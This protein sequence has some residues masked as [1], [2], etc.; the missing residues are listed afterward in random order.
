MGYLRLQ[1]IIHLV[2]NEILI[3]HEK[4]ELDESGTGNVPNPWR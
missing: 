1:R 4:D 2:K 3:A